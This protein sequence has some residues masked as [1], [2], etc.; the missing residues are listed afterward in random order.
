M[1]LLPPINR[2]ILEDFPAEPRKWLGKL[3]Q[4]VNQFF[5]SIYSALN[6]GLTIADNFAGEVKTVELDGTFPLKLTWSQKS[7]PVAVLVGDVYRSDGSAV[8]LTYGVFVKWS[9]NQSAQLQLDAV[10]GISPTSSA[11]YKVSLVCLTG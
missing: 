10:V 9:F 7:K 4:P 1:S 5:E 11:K 6:K 3:I 2:L 8:S